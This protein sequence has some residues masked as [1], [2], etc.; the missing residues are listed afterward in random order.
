M[1]RTVF[2]GIAFCAFFAGC[3]EA[4]LM[5]ML[6]QPDAESRALSYVNLLRQG[7]LDQI[8]HD[9]DPTVTDSNVRATL[10]GMAALFPPGDPESVKVVGAH[11][12]N[13]PAPSRRD[14]S[15]EYQFPNRWLLVT[16]VVQKKAEG[17]T[18]AGLNVLPLADSL[19]N[20][21]RF[22]FAGKG[23]THILILSLAV[24]FFALSV[25]VFVL[26]AQTKNVRAKWLWLLFI[27]VGMGRFAINWT[28][29][30]FTFNLFSFQIPS[31]S[32]SRPLYG[33]WTVAAYL[34]IG[35]MAFLNH[36][37]KM[38]VAGELI[39]TSGAQQ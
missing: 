8:E 36:R 31:C 13:G 27:L 35:A 24:C 25:Y 39:P 29:G 1:W 22:T 11:I 38:K 21:H 12:S 6:V 5:K 30:E 37:W 19:E 20:L 3:N 10:A 17:Y 14:I 15:F 33:P 4:A 18:L 28:T 32:A 23:A 26:C 34:P 2:V 16:V 7:K 9:L